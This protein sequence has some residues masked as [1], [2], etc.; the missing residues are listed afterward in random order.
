VNDAGQKLIVLTAVVA[1]LVGIVLVALLRFMAAA[2]SVRREVRG[3]GE[4]ALLSSALQDALTRVAAQERATS[5]RAV[6]SEQLGAQ[7]FDSLTA[8]LVVVDEGGLVKLANPAAIRMLSL[9]SDVA[10]RPYAELLAR[11]P[12]LIDVL[13]EGLTTRDSVVRRALH[14]ENDT[15]S[16]YFDVTVSPLP[17][18]LRDAR[19]ANLGD[20][21]AP[22]GAICLFSDMTQVV[23]LEQQ[24]HLKDALARLGELTAGIAHE[25][26]NGL[27]TIHGYSRLIDPQSI[28]ERFRPCVEGIRQETDALGHVVTNFLD[29]ARPERIVLAS[30]SLESIVKKAAEDLASELP[31]STAVTTSGA[32]GTIDGDEVL[33][34]QLFANLIRNAAEACHTAG[35]VPAIRITGHIDSVRHVMMVTVEDNGPGIPEG[36][37]GR[38][39]QPFFTTRS[40][41]SGL[42]LSIVQKIALLH[43]G[44]VTVGTS[45]GG[46]AR[47]DLSFPAAR[48]VAAAPMARETSNLL[49]RVQP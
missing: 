14:V 2:R 33:L 3:S 41:G 15:R 21:A 27:A 8:G 49:S 6:A 16:Y 36:D 42:G 13:K 48:T 1:A 23:E 44:S 32:F 38:I 20:A 25:F 39:F 28:P 19:P 7:V 17:G 34:R 4:T 43:N 40:R 35:T 31:S 37:R 11:A 30:L 45:P 47:F 10:G 9:P 26:R 12:L 5:A 29:F 46:G 18:V 24:L 22:T